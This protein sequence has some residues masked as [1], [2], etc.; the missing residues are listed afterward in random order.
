MSGRTKGPHETS[1]GVQGLRPTGSENVPHGHINLTRLRPTGR[2]ASLLISSS[3]STTLAVPATTSSTLLTDQHLCL[4]SAAREGEKLLGTKARFQRSA[5]L[6]QPFD[7]F[8]KINYKSNCHFNRETTASCSIT[9]REEWMSGWQEKQNKTEKQ[10]P[11]HAVPQS[12]R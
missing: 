9:A 4:S 12:W 8:P 3:L 7:W 6:I 11:A 5:S 1:N 2:A 10:N